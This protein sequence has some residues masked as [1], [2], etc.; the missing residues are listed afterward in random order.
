MQIGA[1]TAARRRRS[2]A[3]DRPARARRAPASLALF[4]V[5]VG[6]RLRRLFRMAAGM[7][8]VAGR[9]VGVMRG[10]LVLPGFV[11]LRGFRVVPGRVGVVLRGFLVMFCSLL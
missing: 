9:G 10:D 11:M 5:L 6:V 8:G 1:P 7:N 4:G 2:G 3:K